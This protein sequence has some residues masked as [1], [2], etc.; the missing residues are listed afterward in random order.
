MSTIGVYL[1]QQWIC[2]KSNNGF[3]KE[4]KIQKKKCFPF[5]QSFSVFPKKLLKTMES[6]AA[7]ADVGV[8]WFN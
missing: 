2:L 3:Q 5:F 7:K 4:G 1:Y 8:K 6:I